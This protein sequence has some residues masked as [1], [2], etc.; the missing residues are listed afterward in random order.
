[1]LIGWKY[2]SDFRR[3]AAR[4]GEQYV[5]TGAYYGDTAADTAIKTDIT[6]DEKKEGKR[7]GDE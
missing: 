4:K 3:D 6:E 7:Q 1:M 2:S 5:I